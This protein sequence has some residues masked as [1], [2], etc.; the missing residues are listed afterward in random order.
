MGPRVL[1]CVVIYQSNSRSRRSRVLRRSLLL[2]ACA[3]L[4][5]TQTDTLGPPGLHLSCNLP[6]QLNIPPNL[7][8]TEILPFV[9]LP[10]PSFF[11]DICDCIE[12]A[13]PWFAFSLGKTWFLADNSLRVSRILHPGCEMWCN[14]PIRLKISPFPRITEILGLVGLCSTFKDSDGHPWAPGSSLV[15]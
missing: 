15:L 10:K 9:G 8:I 2:L 12:D 11:Q 7:C 14:L 6:L 5:R 4:S 13:T 3:T 1:T